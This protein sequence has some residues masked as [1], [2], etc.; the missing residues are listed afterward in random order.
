L[1]KSERP[2]NS[3]SIKIRKDAIKPRDKTNKTP[4]S[5]AQF[6]ESLRMKQEKS[7][8]QPTAIIKTKHEI[9]NHTASGIVVGE[10]LRQPL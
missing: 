7:D 10:G 3:P 9:P 4:N 5:L 2:Q 1:N 8:N 6:E